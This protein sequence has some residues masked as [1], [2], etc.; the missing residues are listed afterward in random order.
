MYR[1]TTLPKTQYPLVDVAS[2]AEFILSVQKQDGEIPWSKGGKTDPWDH[3]ESAMGLTIGGCHQEA[4]KAYLWSSRSQLDDGSWWSY[5]MGGKPEKGAYKDS[6]MTAYIAVGLLH[7]YLATGDSEFLRFMWTTV[8]RAIDYVIELQG[9]EGEVFWAKRADGSIDKV[10][11]LTG[12]S[13]IYMSLNC[14]LRIASL[15]GEEKPHWEVARMRL[16]R[17]IRHKPHLF[18]QS[19]SRYSMDWYYPVLCGALTEIEAQKRIQRS[20]NDFTIAGWGVLCV[21][22]QPWVTVAETSELVISLAAIG[23][24]EAAEM[25]FGWILDKKYEDEA[26]WTGVTVPDCEIYTK[27]KTAWTA[28]AVLIAADILYG[29]TSASTLFSHSFWKP[30]PVRNSS[31]SHK[32]T[33]TQRIDLPAIV[34]LCGTQARRAGMSFSPFI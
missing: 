18:D 32:G 13:S 11:L 23:E 33:K 9:T 8:S 19:K 15:L 29:L 16:G 1:T 14:A 27:E 4:R 5:Y 22:D 7:Y 26:F 3:V 12:S 25:V 2:I 17:A 10:A 30:Y 6:N 34:P 21:S 28:A 24:F 31:G 20:W